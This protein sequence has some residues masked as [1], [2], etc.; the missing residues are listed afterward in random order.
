MF[1][2]VWNDRCWPLPTGH[3]IELVVHNFRWKSSKVHLFSFVRVFLVNL[4]AENLLDCCR[5]YLNFSSEPN[6]FHLIILSLLKFIKQNL[7]IKHVYVCACVL[8]KWKMM[9]MMISVSFCHFTC[10]DTFVLVCVCSCL[11]WT[12]F[13][14][15]SVCV[16]VCSV[17]VLFCLVL[18]Y[19]LLP[20]SNKDWLIDWLII[21]S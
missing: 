20:D 11:I 19:G 12:I 18:F 17:V 15:L 14:C 5:F 8:L 9:M 10:L 4:W 7:N 6:I 21:S 13:L 1:S 2:A 3:L 16:Y